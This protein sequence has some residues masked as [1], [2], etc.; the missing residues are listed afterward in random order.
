[1]GHGRQQLLLV[2]AD[3]D[4][5]SGSNRVATILTGARVRPGQYDERIDH[6]GVVRTI[7]D[8]GGLSAIGAAV[9]APAITGVWRRSVVTR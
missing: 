7:F 2:T 1:V 5:S 8:S 6:Y 4:D 9:H 3:E